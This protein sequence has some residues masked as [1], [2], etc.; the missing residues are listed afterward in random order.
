VLWRSSRGLSPLRKYFSV[1]E[2]VFT[3][4]EEALGLLENTSAFLK[5]TLAFTGRPDASS[6]TPPAIPTA[7]VTS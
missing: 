6:K 7:R 4:Q 5:S 1:F 3:G 2:E